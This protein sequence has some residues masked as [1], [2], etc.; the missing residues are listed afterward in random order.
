M[1]TEKLLCDVYK[2]THRD[3]MYLYVNQREGTK[4]VPAELLKLFGEPEKI[5]TMIVTPEKRLARVAGE[6]LM[7]DIQ[8][9]GFYLQM[10]EPPVN[11]LDEYL[12][13]HELD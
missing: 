10:P 13:D 3:E 9:Q 11:Q 6:K 8:A 4:R 7:A 5:L 12:K 2:S 1:S